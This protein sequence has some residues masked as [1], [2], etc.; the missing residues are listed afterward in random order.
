MLAADNMSF[1]EYKLKLKELHFIIDENTT[2]D[3]KSVGVKKCRYLIKHDPSGDMYYGDYDLHGV[4]DEDGTPWSY[5]IEKTPRYSD[6]PAKNPLN[7]SALMDFLNTKFKAKVINHGTQDDWLDRMK[8][9]L[10][11]GPQPPVT[12]YL[13]TGKVERIPR[14]G[15]KGADAMKVFYTKHKL[16]WA[17]EP[18][19]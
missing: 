8:G 5:E 16:P 10:N 1:D 19:F 15:P 18:E 6:D 2:I 4:Y 13:P 12:A 3:E 17:Y 11:K 7:Y 9:P 14:V